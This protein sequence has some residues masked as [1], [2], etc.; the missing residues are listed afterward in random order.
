MSL[1]PNPDFLD[2]EVPRR[3]TLTATTEPTQT[4]VATVT[5]TVQDKD[6]KTTSTAFAL[7]V[8]TTG[9]PPSISNPADDNFEEQT[10]LTGSTLHGFTVADPDGNLNQLKVTAFSSNTNLVPNDFVHNLIVTPPDTS[11]VGHVEVVPNT[12]ALPS[13]SPG[14]GKLPQAATIT[15]SVTDDSYTQQTTFLY[16]LRDPS[17]PRGVL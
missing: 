1:D 14:P 15:L 3:Y 8:P 7:V 9:S 16:V 4:G 2:M 12:A 17:L 5:V 13:P 10:S 6:G 11:G